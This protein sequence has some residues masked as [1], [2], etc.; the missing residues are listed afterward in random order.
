MPSISK[1]SYPII[2]GVTL[3]FLFLLS[4]FLLMRAPSDFPEGK[5]IFIPEGLTLEES[6]ALLKSQKIITSPTFFSILASIL[7]REKIIAGAYV[8]EKRISIFSVALRTTTGDYNV[9]LVRIVFPEGIT[10]SE[11]AE[12]CEKVLAFACKKDEFLTLAK[13]KEGYLFPDTYFFLPTAKADEVVREAEAN[14]EKRLDPLQSAIR[15]FGQPLSSVLTMASILEAEAND[16]ENRRIIA[17]IL[18]KRLSV[19]MPLQVDAPFAYAIGKSTFELTTLD[20]RIDSPYNTYRYKGLPPTPIGNPG[21]EAIEAAVTPVSSKY[22]FYLTG[23]DGKF[24]YATT[25]AEHLRNKA[26]YLK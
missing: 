11:M 13:N 9:D 8:F 24:Y 26:R 15:K 18:W 16:L 20:L 4:Y 6:A 17:G 22:V 21:L 14:F 25:Y 1:E 12:E 2:V 23:R 19:G 7:S 3:G 10:V 5:M